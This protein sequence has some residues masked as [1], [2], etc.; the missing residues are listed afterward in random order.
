M[1]ATDVERA[2]V[3]YAPLDDRERAFHGRMLAL[4]EAAD[5]FSRGA[6][7]PGHFTASAFVL[8][9]RRDAVLLIFHKKLGRWLQPG[10]HIET[11]DTTLLDAARREVAEE[12][13]IVEPV[14]LG[15]GIFDIDVHD[16]PARKDEPAHEHFDVRVL[17][18]AGAL[19]FAASDEVAAARW[20]PLEELATVETDESVRRAIGKIRALPGATAY[21]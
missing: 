18:A 1:R 13:A 3:A 17:L 7:S 6:F 4:C 5:P 10:G 16:I 19:T 15:P 9:P 11:G 14:P 8:S 20:V 12:T 21:R 2:L